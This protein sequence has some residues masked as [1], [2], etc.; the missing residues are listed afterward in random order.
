MSLCCPLGE[1]SG[2]C[3]NEGMASPSL[4][5]HPK[6]HGEMEPTV[7]TADKFSLSLLSFKYFNVLLLRAILLNTL[8]FPRNDYLPTCWP[9]EYLP[10]TLVFMSFPNFIYLF[11]MYGCLG[12][13][14]V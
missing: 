5:K 12:A 1:G 9:W 7:F 4:A 14:C 10:T 11:Y 6:G 13:P 3:R 2:H 8:V